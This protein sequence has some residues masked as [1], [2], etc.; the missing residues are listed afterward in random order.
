M[1]PTCLK[2]LKPKCNTLH[3]DIHRK[4]SDSCNSL[5]NRRLT[6]VEPTNIS[7]LPSELC[8]VGYKLMSFLTLSKEQ[9]DAY[10]DLCL[11]LCTSTTEESSHVYVCQIF[12]G[13]SLVLTAYSLA[14]VPTKLK[15]CSCTSWHAF[16]HSSHLPIYSPLS[17]SHLCFKKW[18]FFVVAVVGFLVCVLIRNL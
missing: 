14:S 13:T 15:T 5:P 16:S 12:S 1:P 7:L 3:I 10:R 17:L 11:F 9:E 2:S 4:I 18:D 6:W 8:L